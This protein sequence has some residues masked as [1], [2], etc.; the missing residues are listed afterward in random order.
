MKG[1][2]EEKE[3]RKRKKGGNKPKPPFYMNNKLTITPNSKNLK[4]KLR[5]IK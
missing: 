5:K 2:V 1:R 3:K 4:A